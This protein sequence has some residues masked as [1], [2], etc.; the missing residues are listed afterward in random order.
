[1]SGRSP[2]KWYVEYV[3]G[4]PMVID[5]HDALVLIV[6]AQAPARDLRGIEPA[7]IERANAEFAAAAPEL[8]GAL[9]TLV[10]FEDPDSVADQADDPRLRAEKARA[11]DS[12]RALLARINGGES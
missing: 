10:E 5:E 9:K 8:E 12:A 6:C 2:G 7:K 1:M 11:V 3:M 4:R